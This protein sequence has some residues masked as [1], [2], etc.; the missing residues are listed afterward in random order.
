MQAAQVV[1]LHNVT[2]MVA[3]DLSLTGMLGENTALQDEPMRIF[4]R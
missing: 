2:I 4:W 1:H 3:Y